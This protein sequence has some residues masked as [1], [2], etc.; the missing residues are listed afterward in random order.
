VRLLCVCVCGINAK[1][2]KPSCYCLTELME[3][4]LIGVSWGMQSA[5]AK[6]GLRYIEV[7]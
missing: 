3:Q 2:K 4:T 7:Q 1:N 6:N 5:G